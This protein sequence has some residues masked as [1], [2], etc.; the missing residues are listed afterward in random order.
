M[1]IIYQKI[2]WKNPLICTKFI[3]RVCEYDGKNKCNYIHTKNVQLCNNYFSEIGCTNNENCIFSHQ[4]DITLPKPLLC[5]SITF[6]YG[7]NREEFELHNWYTK[8]GN[9]FYDNKE[10]IKKGIFQHDRR[11]ML[12]TYAGITAVIAKRDHMIRNAL[13]M[14]E[15]YKQIYMSFIVIYNM[16]LVFDVKRLITRLFFTVYDS[17]YM[18][19]GYKP[20]EESFR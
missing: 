6:P 7:Y 4:I 19:S 8:D 5:F 17:K 1:S 20:I 13:R 14:V 3:H 2:H 15:D 18:N 10:C 11:Y 12:N 16:D 9:N